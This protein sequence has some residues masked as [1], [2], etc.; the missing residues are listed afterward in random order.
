MTNF[1]IH[2]PFRS[3]KDK[4]AKS[5]EQSAKRK[6]QSSARAIICFTFR[7]CHS[8]D[9]PPIARTFRSSLFALCSS[10]FALSSY[11]SALCCSHLGQARGHCPH[12]P[13]PALPPSPGDQP[14]APTGAVLSALC[15]WL[16]A[17]SLNSRLRAPSSLLFALGS[18]L[19]AAKL[20]RRSNFHL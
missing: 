4:A 13:T 16:L 15:A 1:A 17:L 18:L 19:F 6:P 12:T 2:S 11:Q 7:F 5:E 8:Q 9:D 14:V 10:L 20:P 3:C